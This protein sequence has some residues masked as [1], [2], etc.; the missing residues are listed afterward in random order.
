MS[1]FDN[2]TDVMGGHN[3]HQEL[4]KQTRKLVGKWEP[5][6]LLDDIEDSTK[7]Q[8]MAVLLENQATQLIKEA[9]ATG[10]GGNKEEWSGVALPLVRRIFGELSAQEFVSVQP[11]NLPSGLIFF[12]DFKYGSANQA[13]ILQNT[14]VFGNTSSSVDLMTPA[15]QSKAGGLYGAG[16]FG[17][18]INDKSTGVFLNTGVVGPATCA[19]S[20]ATWKELEFEPSLSQSVHLGAIRKVNV[21]V[22]AFT[23]ADFAGIKAFEMSG[24][25]VTAFYP[26]YSAID[27]LASPATASFFIQT[28]AMPAAGPGVGVKYHQ[29]PTA[30][31]RGDFEQSSFTTP[32]PSTADD[33]QIP[34][35]DIQLKSE[36]IVAKTRKLKAVWTP[37]L[38]Q[39]LNAY[40]SVDA[41]AELTAM[42]SEYIAM[43][44]DLEILD[45]LKAHASAKTSY[46]SAKVGYEYDGSGTGE[47]A[48]SQISGASNAYTKSDWFQTLGIKIQGVSNAI[49]QK[50]LRGG[51]N[52]VVVSPE[53]STILESVSGYI[54]NA[55]DAKSKSYAMGVE[56]V[57]SINNRYTVYKNPYMVDNSILVGFR[58]SNFLETGAVYAPYVPMIMTPLVYDPQNFTPRKGVMTRY[59]KKMVRSEFY[60]KVIVAHSDAI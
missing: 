45:M 59:A 18:S 17:Y 12:L 10:T 20:S 42:L 35:V 38:A 52:F 21:P 30:A 4:L 57:G 36:A 3:P 55:G 40:H 48:W 43:E 14:D 6:G 31:Q 28:G 22:S 5:T 9:S 50:T 39:D 47:G 23:R 58:G 54:A 51:A 15:S 1:N 16:K 26:Q 2:I 49:H 41:E 33:L 8:G 11:M 56:A 60:G 37:E 32:G 53:T 24:S 29:Q 46:W 34:E 25:N 44:I 27:S 13:N 19:T 7:K